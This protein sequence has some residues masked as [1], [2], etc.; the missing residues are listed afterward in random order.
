MSVIVNIV[1]IAM[2]LTAVATPHWAELGGDAPVSAGLFQACIEVNKTCL[3]TNNHFD[4]YKSG[5]KKLAKF[6]TVCR[7][8]DRFKYN[9][10]KIYTLPTEYGSYLIRILSRILYG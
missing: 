8:K 10:V 6:Y 3:D 1:S 7:L 5:N 4:S 2:F 9:E